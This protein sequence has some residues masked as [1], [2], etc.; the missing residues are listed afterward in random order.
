MKTKSLTISYT[1]SAVDQIFPIY[2]VNPNAN[3]AVV[4]G[5]QVANFADSSMK[6]TIARIEYSSKYPNTTLYWGDGS[7]KNQTFYY[8]SSAY[9]VLLNKVV[10]YPN[11]ALSILDHELYLKPRDVITLRPISVGSSTSFRPTIT[12]IESY[13]DDADATTVVDLN[14]VFD[15]LLAGTY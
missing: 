8:D 6:C 1:P 11:A 9:Q 7:I 5:L 15:Q 12:V 4:K 3:S 10:I 13:D 2:A 14:M